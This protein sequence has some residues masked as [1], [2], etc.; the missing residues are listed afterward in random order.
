MKDECSNVDCVHS[1]F[2]LNPSYTRVMALST[3]AS[4]TVANVL[5]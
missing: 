5:A 2:I 3:S 1:S 4:G